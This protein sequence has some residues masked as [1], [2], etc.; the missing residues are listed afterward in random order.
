MSNPIQEILAPLEPHWD[1][2]VRSPLSDKEI[3]RLEKDVGVALPDVLKQYLAEI[4]LYQDLTN[5]GNSTIELHE[6][7]EQFAAARQYVA[8]L[9]KPTAPELFPFGGDGAGNE[10]CLPT[11]H[12]L[13]CRIHFVDHETGK[14]K[15]QKE[16]TV[17][18]ESVVKKVVRGI[19]RRPLN[20][21]KVWSVQFSF[22]STPFDRLV[23][24]LG[25][26]GKVQ[27]IDD[28]WKNSDTS[29]AEVT[30]TDR[31]IEFNGAERKI[32][33]L[34]CADWEF[35]M[36]SLTL[37]EPVLTPIEDSQIRALIA[38]FKNNCPDYKLVNYGA[39]D[40]DEL[41]KAEG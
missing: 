26:V 22:N 20:E 24:L 33:R 23:E 41:R 11:D 16:F 9:V 2:V 7:P 32:G 1:R 18:L 15:K 38:V 5:W 12:E 13:P 6:K 30:S 36:I 21:K 4:G 31:R 27:V 34:E 25:S 35:P 39:L 40:I 8:K 28:D 37:R 29:P 17:W 3:K 19:K 14:V 10:F